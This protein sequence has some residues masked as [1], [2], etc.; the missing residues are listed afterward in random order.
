MRSTTKGA[1]ALAVLSITFIPEVQAQ[2]WHPLRRQSKRMISFAM[3]RPPA[4][5]GQPGLRFE[6]SSRGG[7][8]NLNKQVNGSK[9]KILTALAPTY[10]PTYSGLVLGMTAAAH[11]TFWF[12][13][14]YLGALPGKFVLQEADKT[15]YQT[16]VS[17]PGTPGVVRVS[18]P[19]KIAPLKIGQSYHWFFNVYCQTGQPPAFVHGWIK[20]DSLNPGLKTQL[21]RSNEEERVA[22]YAANG[23]WYDALNTSDKL[24]HNDPKDSNW[25]ALLK[26]VGLDDVA[27]EPVVVVATRSKP[28]TR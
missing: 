21:E 20:R 14:P 26:A 24:R 23:L 8:E 5:L 22:L 18:L 17:L 7:C 4:T 3:P 1:L 9:E 12:Y 16:P 2:S 19:S 11:P 10:G 25:V 6:A 13:V 28:V 27:P 15:I